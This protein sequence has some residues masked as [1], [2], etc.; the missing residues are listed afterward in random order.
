[1]K[2]IKNKTALITGG[3]SGLGLSLAKELAEENCQ[4]IL[5][6]IDSN[7]LQRAEEYF[8]LRGITIDCYVVDVS[9]RK[10]VL[11]TVDAIL[12][13]HNTIDILI[14]NAGVAAP[15]SINDI[16]FDNLEWV[17]GINFW[18]VIHFTKAILPHMLQRD[19]GC[20]VNISSLGGY[21]TVPNSGIYSASKYAIRAI[22]E[23]L[24]Q[25]VYGTGI[26]IVSVHPGGLSTDMVLRARIGDSMPKDTLLKAVNQHSLTTPEKAASIIVNAIKKN[27]FRVI[28]GID[29]K[30]LCFFERIMPL[31]TNTFMVKLYNYLTSKK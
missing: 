6:D 31:L 13:K 28:I 5:I 22:S 23:T 18:G 10:T 12:K 16:S 15:A 21:V 26:D 2:D 19:Q 9:N 17:M 8:S 14:N 25:E 24:R 27:Q 29:A 30:I 7:A 4:I 20:I 3:A 1:M 11:S